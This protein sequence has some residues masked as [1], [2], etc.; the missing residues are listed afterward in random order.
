MKT[1]TYSK[2]TITA[3]GMLERVSATRR[4]QLV[5]KLQQL[6]LEQESESK[7]EKLLETH[8]EPM[9]TM[10]GNALREHQKGRSKPL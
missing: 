3:I 4:K 1:T 9:L 7:W 10:A 2:E 5:E 8:P 6:M